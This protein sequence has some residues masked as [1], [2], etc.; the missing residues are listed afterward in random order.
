MRNTPRALSGC[1]GTS[2]CSG[3]RGFS[4]PV[5][6]R[7]TGSRKSERLDERGEDSEKKTQLKNYKENFL[8]LDFLVPN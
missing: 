1:R 8:L 3:G 7:S 6:G 4:G 2:L 5:V